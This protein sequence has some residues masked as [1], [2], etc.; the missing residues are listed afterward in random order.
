M[1]ADGGETGSAGHRES[2]YEGVVQIGADGKGNWMKSEWG[3]QVCGEASAGPAARRWKSAAQDLRLNSMSDLF[4]ENVTDEMLDRHLR[5]DGALPA[6][7]VSGADEAGGADAGVSEQRRCWRWDPAPNARDRVR[8]TEGRRACVDSSAG[9]CRTS[10]LVCRR[11]IRKAADAR[12][13]LLLQTPA[14]R[15]FISAEPLL[16]AVTLRPEWL[17]VGSIEI[18]MPADL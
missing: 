15:H 4:H 13:P 3:D 14:W 11:R 9:H 16:G 8:D 1:A 12:I 6:A 2:P 10:I 5:G 18:K 17:N 7:Y